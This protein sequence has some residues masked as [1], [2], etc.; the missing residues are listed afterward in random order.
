MLLPT[1][2]RFSRWISALTFALVCAAAAF[3]QSA[4]QLRQIGMVD[5]PGSPGFDQVAFAKGLLLMTHTSA[6]ALDVVDPAKRRVVAQVVNLQSPRGIAVDERNGKVYIAQEGN[7]SIA[8]ISFDGWQVTGTIPVAA[9]PTSLLLDDSGQRLYWTSSLNNTLSVVDL[10]TRQTTA[11]AALDGQPQAM[12]WDPDREVVFVTLQD[13]RQVVAVDP[14][15]Q[16][17]S[18][19]TLQGS[20]PTGLAYDRVSRRLYVAVRYGVLSISAENGT[21]T[22]RVAAPAGV[23]RLWLDSASST[24]YA[25]GSGSLLVMRA[26][27]GRLAALDEIAIDIKGHS[28]A[29]DAERK[30]VLLPGGRDG[31]SKIML[32]RP[33]DFEKQSAPQENAQARLH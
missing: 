3:A 7:N 22:N 14:K 19:F 31:R 18:R 20:Q 11:T 17:V 8:V 27:N 32:L 10:T 26:E 12:V 24:L 23:D 4:P 9:A 21:E 2:T 16:V 5:V 30:L 6:S 29:Y 28:V 25:A 15:L 13:Q 33:M 1:T